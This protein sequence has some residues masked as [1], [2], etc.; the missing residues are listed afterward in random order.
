MRAAVLLVWLLLA[1]ALSACRVAGD[2]GAH[3]DR[4]RL[5]EDMSRQLERGT[6]VRYQAVYQLAGGLR[7][8]VG[9]QLSPLRTSYG[10]PGGLLIVAES[11]RTSCDVAVAP[12]RC[13]I[14]AG[15]GNGQ[16]EPL[17]AVTRKGLVTAPVVTQLLRLATQQRAATVKGHD[18][19]VAGMPASCLEILNLTDAIAAS[20]SACVTADGVL[21][22]FSG[23]IDGTNVDQ[24]LEELELRAPDP[25]LFTVPGNADVVDLRQA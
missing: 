7:A 5:V 10:Y 1:A 6:Q 22:S 16:A 15:G 25:G 13:E 14:R 17:A 21:A 24:A 12:V 8:T 11:D 20:F 19:T 4:E 23:L 3:I 2:G 9:H 18:T